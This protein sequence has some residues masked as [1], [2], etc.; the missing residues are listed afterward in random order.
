MGR[1]NGTWMLMGLFFLT[2]TF[3]PLDFMIEMG[4]VISPTNTLEEKTVLLFSL[5]KLVFPWLG[6]MS[7]LWVVL[8]ENG[9]QAVRGMLNKIVQSPYTLPG[10][11]IIGAFL[12]ISWVYYFPTKLY[13]DSI[14]YFRNATELAQGQ[15]FVYALQTMQPLVGWP[16]GYP[17]FLSLIFR[18]TGPSLWVAKWINILLAE[19]GI[20]LAYWLGLQLFNRGVAVLSAMFIACLPGLIVYTGLVATD[21]LFMT[22]ALA[23]FL[24]SLKDDKWFRGPGVNGLLLGFVSGCLSLVRSTGLFLFPLW[25]IFQ[26]FLL[27]KRT[28]FLKWVLGAGIGMGMVVLP[29]TLRNYYHFGVLIPVSANGGANFWIGNN[30]LAYG[31]YIFPNNAELNPL[32][33]LIGQQ[34]ELDQKGYALGMEYI[35]THP[36]RTIELL[37]AKIFYL[38][39]SNDFGLH[40]SKL[41]AVTL[42][43]P[44]SGPRAFALINL[45]YVILA[46]FGL[47]GVLNV[48]LRNT[49]RT[50]LR[51]HGLY[52][53]LYWTIIHLPFFGQDRF[54]LPL[55]PVLGYYAAL[56]VMAWLGMTG[57]PSPSSHPLH[58]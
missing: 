55:I 30:P 12:R 48:L 26:W 49:F 11:L 21:L 52:L 54:S 40:W 51:L 27:Q 8:P 32:Y 23:C 10:I 43:Q 3:I 6:V 2:I 44:G 37:P 36:V 34:I 13:A 57:Y 9:K 20:L 56:G 28:P 5:I 46:C 16:V 7:L 4:T 22:L 45:L 38:Y 58:D 53:T 47:A 31:G 1:V 35:R 19:C 33:P 25:I 15:G 24:L 29:W 50:P 42:N 41:S 17:A 39:N 18:L 14:W